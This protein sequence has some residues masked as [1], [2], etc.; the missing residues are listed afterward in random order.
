MDREMCDIRVT[1]CA[2]SVHKD[3]DNETW[4]ARP[5]G[6]SPDPFEGLAK[7]VATNVVLLRTNT[8]NVVTPSFA[9]DKALT[10]ATMWV[11]G[12]EAPVCVH[13]CGDVEEHCRKA[14]VVVIDEVERYGYGTRGHFWGVVFDHSLHV[15]PFCTLHGMMSM[16]P[17]TTAA[18]GG[19]T[20]RHLQLG[21]GAM[22]GHIIM[23]NLRQRS[24]VRRTLKCKPLVTLVN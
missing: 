17:Y 3:L 14:T 18:I 19:F 9:L 8:Y 24:L 2:S 10:S 5:Q 15:A 22:K 4:G 7:H 12:R 13:G 16:L 21:F 1:E 6:G 23:A 11:L 20:V